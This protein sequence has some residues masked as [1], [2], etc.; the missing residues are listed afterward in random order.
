MFELERIYE[1]ARNYEED[2]TE[3]VAHGSK[4]PQKFLSKDWLTD[5]KMEEDGEEDEVEEE[6]EE[7][8]DE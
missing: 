4:R 7:E 2:S 3:R 5:V 1:E 8:E 6:E